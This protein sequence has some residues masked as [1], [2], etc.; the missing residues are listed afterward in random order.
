M[1]CTN[2]SIALILILGL[3]VSP[4]FAQGPLTPPGPPA[5]T[6]K[7]LSQVEPRTP[8]TNAAAV[9]ISTSGSYYL[10]TNI[11]VTAGNAITIAADNV[12]LDLNGFTITSTEAAHTG[13]GILLNSGLRHIR[14]FNGNIREN[15]TQS[16]GVFS[17]S[18]FANGIYYTGT[19][20]SNVR[21]SGVSVS[22]CQVYGI[23]LFIYSTVVE[24]CTVKTAGSYGIVAD[25]VSDST[26]IECGGGGIAAITAQNCYGAAVGSGTGLNA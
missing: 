23:Y 5:P 14:I 8:I 10:T 7:T 21:V 20:P 19:D 3:S 9:T 4:I 6:M 1:K 11:A 25:S 26:A 22:G 15:I 16:G 17:G 2:H 13:T 12:T 18:G 24:S